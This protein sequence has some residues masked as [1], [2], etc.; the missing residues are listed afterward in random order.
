MFKVVI[1]SPSK[2]DISKAACWYNSKQKG[3]GKR[4][5]AQIRSKVL[6][7]QE[8]PEAVAI[9][10]DETRCAVLKTFPFI[11][12]YIIGSSQKKVIISAVFHTSLN[13]E[14]WNKR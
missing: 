10:Y 12:H 2:E 9:L 8:N 7:I 4:F 5:I 3:L 11:I 1:L 6:F 14:K 13:P